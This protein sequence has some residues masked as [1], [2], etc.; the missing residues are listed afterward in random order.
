MNNKKQTQFN[1]IIIHSDE[2]GLKGKNR[3]FFEQ[4]L[5]SNLKNSLK[6]FDIKNVQKE[7]GRFTIE[8]KNDKYNKKII[9]VLNKTPGVSNFSFGIKCDKEIDKIKQCIKENIEIKESKTFRITTQRSDKKFPITSVEVDKEMGGVILEKYPDLKVK[10]ENPDIN[11]QIEIAQKNCY[12]Y[13]NKHYGIGGLPVG[14]TGRMLCLLSG[15]IDSPVAAFMMAKRGV[16]VDFIHFHNQ[17][18]Q[19]KA[20]KT[21]IEKIVDV[22]SQYQGKTDLHIVPFADIQ[23]EIIAKTESDIRMLIYRRFMIRIAEKIANKNNTKGLITGDSLAQ[24]ASQTLENINVV[25]NVTNMFIAS[26]LI[27]MNKTEIIKIAQEIG[28]YK[29]S[30]EPYDDCCQMLIAKHPKTRAKLSDIENAESKISIEV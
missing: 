21:K 11:I 29:I 9:S 19:S 6:N 13:L 3:S 25:H 1:T 30:I 10:L 20:V 23:K 16:K 17:T 27:G 14:S 15:G 18:S 28:T 8:L 12:I 22:I 7:Y 26:P 5:I 2:I 24:V 4:K